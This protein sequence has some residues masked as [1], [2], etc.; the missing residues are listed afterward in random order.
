[1]IIDGHTHGLYGAYL[2]SL[3]KFGVDLLN[4]KIDQMRELAQEIPQLLDVS[5]RVQQLDTFGID[6]QVVTPMLGEL[7]VNMIPADAPTQLALSRAINDNMARLMED[8]KGRL[9][10][11][12]SPPVNHFGEDNRREMERAVSLGLRGFN[13][14]SNINGKPLDSA[15]YEGFWAQ[16]NSMDVALYIHPVPYNPRP[17]EKEYDLNHVFGWPFETVLTLSR[18]VFSGI[19]ERYPNLRIA[20]HH[21]GGGMIPFFMGRL[22]ESNDATATVPNRPAPLPKP[23]YDYFARFFYDTAVGGSPAA[24]KCCCEVFGASQVVLATDAPHGPLKGLKRLESYP[25]LIRTLGLPSE[26]T[27]NILSGN[28]RRLLKLNS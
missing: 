13:L 16:L 3:T 2:D 17:Y 26:D 1:M 18:L 24:I 23:L 10:A 28:T 11:I 14:P 12:G 6:M 19:M 21:L 27:E 22:M 20:S 9:I 25:A 15:E 8:S 4:R 7:E 5:L